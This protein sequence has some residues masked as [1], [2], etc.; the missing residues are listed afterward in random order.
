M[1]TAKNL[2]KRA[3]VGSVVFFAFLTIVMG[4]CSQTV[5][6]LSTKS[7][8]S[9]S[10]VIDSLEIPLT[11][12]S[13]KSSS[14][15]SAVIDS[16]EEQLTPSSELESFFDNEIGGEQVFVKGVIVRLLSD[17]TDGD[18]HQRFIISLDNEQTLLVAHN[19]DVGTRV[20]NV[21]VGE[22]VYVFGVYEWNAQGGVVHW[23]H[24]SLDSS[25]VPG[26]IIYHGVQYD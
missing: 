25:H 14:S 18:A 2:K 24:Q 13:T 3:G 7:S 5:S 19:I 21:K 11:S 23:T 12:S 6:P 22:I 17:D 16:L 15:E 9:E 8:S 4:A 26:F 10:A 20:A 1:K